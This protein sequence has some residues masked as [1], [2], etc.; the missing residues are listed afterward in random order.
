M[1]DINRYS[2]KKFRKVPKELVN[3]LEDT[4]KSN[5]CRIERKEWKSKYNEYVVYDCEPFCS[6]G[7]DINILASSFDY[8]Y[9]NFVNYLY[10]EKKTT[11]EH[12]QS[13][14]EAEYK[15]TLLERVGIGKK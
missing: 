10:K 2:H 3:W 6:D 11:L 15:P 1:E 5:N 13:C 12:L 14:F 4:L 8:S 9:L 7:S